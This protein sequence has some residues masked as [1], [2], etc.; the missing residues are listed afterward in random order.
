VCPRCH[1][2]GMIRDLRSLSLSIMRAIE[3]IALRERQGEVQLQVPIEIAAFLLN[4]KRDSLIYLEQ[5]SRCRITILP[6]PHLETPHYHISFNRD[7]NPPASY[8]LIER[9]EELGY[10]TDWQQPQ[11]AGAP[12]RQAPARG[13]QKAAAAPQ[14]AQAP[15]APQPVAAQPAAQFA[16]LEN[17]FTPRQARPQSATTSN[18]AASAIEQMVN[19]GAVSR[20]IYGEVSVPAVRAVVDAGNAYATGAPSAQTTP[21]PA[22]SASGKRDRNNRN[23]RGRDNTNN[24]SNT[25][26]ESNNDSQFVA[27]T[28]E[29]APYADETPTPRNNR[30]RR[31]NQNDNSVN[32]RDQR[33]ATASG[34]EGSN[35]N[36][37][38]RRDRNSNR[39]SR[40]P[41]QR[42]ASVLDAQTNVIT[43]VNAEA[44][45]QPAVD[46]N[47]PLATRVIA[48]PTDTIPANLVVFGLDDNTATSVTALN[49]D[50]ADVAT[51]A[52]A[53]E[54]AVEVTPVVAGE[55][56]RA[57]NDPRERRRRRELGLDQPVQALSGEQPTPSIHYEPVTVQGSV[58]DFV[59]AALGTEGET[60]LADGRVVEAFLTA[61]KG[62]PVVTEVAAA[63]VDAEPANVILVDT[64]IV[65]AEAA[66]LPPMT[67]EVIA[68]PVAD[69]PR[70]ANDPRMRRRL[71]AEAAAA[72]S[73]PQ[74]LSEIPSDDQMPVEE[75][76][77]SAPS[78]AASELEVDVSAVPAVEAVSEDTVVSSDD[79]TNLME[80]LTE[81]LVS[82][83]AS[84]DDGA[85]DDDGVDDE[86]EES[87]EPEGAETGS[88]GR[89]RRPRI[90]GRP[91]KK[92][93]PVIE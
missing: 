79:S 17:L 22:Q 76:V 73:A 33:D 75:A 74:V 51:P 30:N 32:D 25:N 50:I 55:V 36:A 4:E 28:I 60:L 47:D 88:R 38:V 49:A 91:P 9:N 56:P 37:P 29:A 67:T 48:N 16:W 13:N 83:D 41:R 68:P 82:A 8:E 35:N 54:P 7:G 71:A 65:A 24:N 26:V 19:G 43:A 62:R 10:A 14:A 53:T 80:P 39:N 6:H 84:E 93:A 81:I 70:A 59:R 46:V 27:Q 89:P 77:E 61:L 3:E 90:G 11:A 44:S 21:Q 45:A 58:G 23:R 40:G 5:S 92:R 78:E 34:E 15:Q 1:G 42:D 31:N 52:A 87:L 57:A 12:V 69:R 20:G 85:S 63:P 72:A 66:S 86:S 64:S 18:D 2:T